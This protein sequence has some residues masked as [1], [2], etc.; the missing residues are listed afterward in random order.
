M[1]PG[2]FP[3]NR[4][5]NK[6]GPDWWSGVRG[7]K[8]TN[9]LYRKGRMSPNNND[10]VT[11]PDD[12]QNDL[13]PMIEAE[14]QPS[15]S[16][17]NYKASISFLP[18][19]T[20]KTFKFKSVAEA[21]LQE[22]SR[23][24]LAKWRKRDRQNRNDKYR[25]KDMTNIE[26]FSRLTEN[27]DIL[28][29][30]IKQQET[31]INANSKAINDR[32][33]K[34]EAERKTKEDEDKEK[35]FKLE[36]RTENL[37]NEKDPREKTNESAEQTVN[38]RQNGPDQTL[39]Q[40]GHSVPVPTGLLSNNSILDTAVWPSISNKP[41]VPLPS[42]Q[43]KP[44]SSLH[45]PVQP[46]PVGYTHPEKKT[47]EQYTNSPS[48]ESFNTRNEEAV[49]KFDD[50]KHWA[51]IKLKKGIIDKFI[52]PWLG[53]QSEHDIIF[54]SQNHTAREECLKHNIEFFCRIHSDD[55]RIYEHYATI[56]SGVIL[57]FKTDKHIAEAIYKA[58]PMIRSQEFQIKTYIPSIARDRKRYID[59]I[60][61]DYKK[62][63][64][65]DLRFI[66]KNNTTDLEVLLKST[67]PNRLGPYRRI[68]PAILGE[69]P[70]LD[71]KTEKPDI[72]TTPDP[73]AI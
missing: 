36:K 58:A 67:K 73:N 41:F 30:K 3:G 6:H 13:S 12:G 17:S 72:N 5:T 50:A 65:S 9:L 18:N 60:L 71:L 51:G 4:R 69:V 19:E 68:D 56:S 44:Q 45:I 11:L 31:S 64:D 25:D 63:V 27:F 34:I 8:L 29:D 43:P 35:I 33:D 39:R 23:E 38:D 22:K 1:R 54:A 24:T 21:S 70:D 15:A 46:L 16:G 10:D 66:V 14:P 26:L 2:H 20:N 52:W 28:E 55:I 59:K 53:E 42:S 62:D 48:K 32:I 37:K 47:K 61:L 57:W 40:N 49:K 7:S